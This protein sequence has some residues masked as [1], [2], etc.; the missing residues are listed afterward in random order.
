MGAGGGGSMT[1]TAASV[2][3]TPS[4]GFDA[5]IHSSED[6]DEAVRQ[7]SCWANTALFVVSQPWRMR[8]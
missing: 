5:G 1:K 2:G 4:T 7:A 6:A 3:T 8:R